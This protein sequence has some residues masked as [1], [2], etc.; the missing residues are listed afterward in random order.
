[1]IPDVTLRIPA[2]LRAFTRHLSAVPV[3]AGTVSAA[4]D[5]LIDLFPGL[6]SHLFDEHGEVRS[7]VN[8]YR[9]DEDIRYLDHG[10][11]ELRAGDELVI[12]PSIAGGAA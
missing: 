12:V 4:L 11:T 3:R 7:F 9:N 5:A 10:R 1:M 2:P 6:R 8:L